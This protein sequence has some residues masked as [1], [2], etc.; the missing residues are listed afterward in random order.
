MCTGNASRKAHH[1]SEQAKRQAAQIVAANDKRSELMQRQVDAIK[2][3][4]TPPPV[5]T[6][7]TIA[8]TGGVKTAASK[9]KSVLAINKGIA[10]LRNPLNTGG[11]GSNS[12]V[13]I[14]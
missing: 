9:R 10:A 8:T 2:P 4:I 11:S 13:N 14:G 7:S 6:N 12:N 1:A 3:R 5:A